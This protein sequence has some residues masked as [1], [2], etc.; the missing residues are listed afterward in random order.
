MTAYLVLALF[1]LSVISDEMSIFG[2]RS[3]AP[4]GWKKGLRAPGI[5]CELFL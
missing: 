1:F 3:V 5:N 2:T 4:K